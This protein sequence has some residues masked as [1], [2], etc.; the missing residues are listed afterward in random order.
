MSKVHSRAYL[1]SRYG[2]SQWRWNA[3]RRVLRHLG[4]Y[5]GQGLEMG[6]REARRALRRYVAEQRQLAE[7]GDYVPPPA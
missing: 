1:C 5:N 4:I 2:F 6:Y 3:A 7:R